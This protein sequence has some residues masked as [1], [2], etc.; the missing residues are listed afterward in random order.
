M[1]RRVDWLPLLAGLPGCAVLL[2]L[3]LLPVGFLIARSVTDPK[4]GLS[5]YHTIITSPAYGHAAW[6]TLWLSGAAVL[7][8][9]LLGTPVAY[10]LVRAGDHPV[11]RV[12]MAV[13]ILSFLT[14]SLVRAYAWFLML[15]TQGPVVAVTNAL[16]LGK[17]QLLFNSFAVI[18]GMVHYLLPIYTLMLYGSLRSIRYELVTAAEGLGAKHAYALRTVFLPLAR[19]GLVNGGSLVFV[20]ALGF[21]VTP[22]L[23]GGA[24]QTMLSQLIAQAVQQFGDFGAAAATG[25]LLLV[26]SLALLAAVRRVLLPKSARY[27]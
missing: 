8:C 6:T 20:I 22:A 21:F 14:S 25:F 9:V 18:V 24:Q 3:F 27:G 15:G 11:M 23:L 5:N 4:L 2:G 17:P 10:A 12:V 19:P 7:G 16:G 26:A 13:L 1:R